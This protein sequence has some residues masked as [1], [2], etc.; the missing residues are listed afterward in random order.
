MVRCLIDLMCWLSKWI[1]LNKIFKDKLSLDTIK[2]IWKKTHLEGRSK[3][4]PI[5]T[6][7]AY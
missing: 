5:V 1:L 7:K 2:T 6:P 4:S 3:A